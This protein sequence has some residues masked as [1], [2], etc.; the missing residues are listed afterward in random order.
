MSFSMYQ[1]TVTDYMGKRMT[2]QVAIHLLAAVEPEICNMRESE[3]IELV[4]HEY[5]PDRKMSYRIQSGDRIPYG[6]IDIPGTPRSEAREKLDNMI[7]ALP[8][9][10]HL[11][12][13]GGGG[14]GPVELVDPEVLVRFV[15]IVKD[16]AERYMEPVLVALVIQ[17]ISQ[18]MEDRRDSKHSE[19]ESEIQALTDHVKELESKLAKNESH[20]QKED[21]EVRDHQNLLAC[22]TVPTENNAGLES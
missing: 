11:F 3:Q 2:Y 12:A 8:Q 14:G 15:A 4:N 10:D 9:P 19:Q 20:S 5:A 1:N 22:A 21:Q 18:Y 7:D 6:Y 13:V 17:Q 16:V